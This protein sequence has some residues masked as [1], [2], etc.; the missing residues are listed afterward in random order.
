MEKLDQNGKLLQKFWMPDGENV[1]KANEAALRGWMEGKKIP[2]GVPDIPFFLLAEQYAE[3]R[4]KAV[5]DFQ[6]QGWI[7]K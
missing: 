5:E 2:S 7:P 3:L 1:S 6:Q 4:A